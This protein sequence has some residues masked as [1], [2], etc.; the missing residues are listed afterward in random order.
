MENLSEDD[1]T[2]EVNIDALI[3]SKSLNIDLVQKLKILEPF[4]QGNPRP[5]FVTR[6]LMLTEEPLIMK[7]KHLKL[8]LADAE[9]RKFEAIWWSGG[10]LADEKDLSAG[11][12]LE[13]AY[14]PEI[15]TWNGNQ[16]LQLV[17]EDIRS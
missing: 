17:V 8:R 1:L 5:V 7:E 2:P 6:D 14:S 12:V 9:H 13:V 11:N 15:N 10:E 3:T 4:G 16:R